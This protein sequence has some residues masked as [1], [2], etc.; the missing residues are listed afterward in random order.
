MDYEKEYNDLI[1]RI[2]AVKNTPKIGMKGKHH[3]D[4]YVESGIRDA[5]DYILNPESED[6]TIRETLAKLIVADINELIKSA[7]S[8]AYFQGVKEYLEDVR[9]FAYNKGLVDAAEKQK[10]AEWSE[11]DKGA[12][13]DAICAADRLGN[14][15][16]F[17]KSNPNLAKAFRVAKD[18]LKSLP[19]RF[20][21]QPEQEVV[22]RTVFDRIADILRW[23][24]LPIGCPVENFK[25]SESEREHLLNI[26]QCVAHRYANSCTYCKEYSRGYQDGLAVPHW[27]PSEKQINALQAFVGMIHPDARYDA[28]FSLLDE[29]KA[30]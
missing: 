10:P 18:W 16:S 6:E 29:L 2:N 27:K 5:L 13:K 4:G 9:Q 17:N 28:V 1:A 20:T 12:L 24:D 3:Y 23:C 22:D 11:F 8:R 30:L 14:D 19:E 25:E 15:E 26:V 7:D 21:L